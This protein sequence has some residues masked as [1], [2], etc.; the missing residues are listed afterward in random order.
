[1]LH[2]SA[3]APSEARSHK[4]GTCRGAARSRRKPGRRVSAGRPEAPVMVLVDTS[5]WIRFLA[6]RDPI[7]GQLDALLASDEVVGHD[8]VFGELLIG[9]CGGREGIL[10]AYAKLPYAQSIPHREVVAMVRARRLNGRGAGWIDVHLLASAIVG[11]FSLWTAE[12]RFST[13]ARELG[14]EHR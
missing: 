14:V 9:D 13:I 1:M 5:V 3:C 6:N 11:A 7:A 2:T 10:E 8:L 12:A 4:H